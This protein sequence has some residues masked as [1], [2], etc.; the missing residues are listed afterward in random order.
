MNHL[1][2]AHQLLIDCPDLTESDLIVQSITDAL[3]V[4]HQAQIQRQQRH[5]EQQLELFQA[6]EYEPIPFSRRY[7]A[8]LNLNA[9]TSDTLA[10]CP[11]SRGHLSLVQPPPIK[12]RQLH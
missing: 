12:A 11:P 5:H 7:R 6:D 1:P 2:H 8:H 9:S 4:Q 3:L 10:R